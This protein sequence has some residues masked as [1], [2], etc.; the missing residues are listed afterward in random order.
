MITQPCW[1]YSHNT[2]DFH[3]VMRMKSMRST[4][5]PGG[6]CTTK[7]IRPKLLQSMLQNKF[8]TS[9]I[10]VLSGRVHR[11]HAGKTLGLKESTVYTVL[12]V[13]LTLACHWAG[14]WLASDELRM[15]FV[16]KVDWWAVFTS[17]S[18]S[19]R[20]VVEYVFRLEIRVRIRDSVTVSGKFSLRLTVRDCRDCKCY[21]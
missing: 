6:W 17:D 16:Y 18:A 2:I 20:I 3:G 15:A 11:C 14:R 13:L 8:S 9:N 21:I 10:L 5:V 4:R 12:A 7:I 1:S 19:I